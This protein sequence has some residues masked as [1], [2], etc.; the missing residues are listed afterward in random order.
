[1]GNHR[2]DPLLEPRVLAPQNF[3]RNLVERWIIRAEELVEVE[4]DALTCFETEGIGESD[5]FGPP[6][7]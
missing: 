5:R 3:H 2:D 4:L 1:M 6:L 7:L